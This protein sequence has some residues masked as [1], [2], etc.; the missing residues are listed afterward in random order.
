MMWR[1]HLDPLLK[2]GH[3][4]YRMFVMRENM[5]GT[6]EMIVGPLQIKS[7]ERSTAV[8]Y[9]DAFLDDTSLAHEEVRN[10]LQACADA[11]WDIGIRP[12][13]QHESDSELKAVKRHL[14]DMRTLV[15]DKPD[16]EV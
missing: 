3:L 10:F 13:Q 16:K 1:V 14:E 8:P 5:H 12:R 11:A 7:Y 15:L 2:F 6:F 9:G 4:G